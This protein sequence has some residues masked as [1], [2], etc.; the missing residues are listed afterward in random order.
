MVTG[1]SAYLLLPLEATYE[2]A[3]NDLDSSLVA[4]L[5]S[6]LPAHESVHRHT[7]AEALGALESGEAQ[8][9]F[10]LRPVTVSQIE[11]WAAE[12]TQMP[13]K[14]TYFTPKPRTGMV[15]RSLDL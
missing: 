14:T 6:H 15:F 10:L 13:P 1:G 12:R 9:A 3:G 8:A 11:T 2:A 7:V 5:L 4:V